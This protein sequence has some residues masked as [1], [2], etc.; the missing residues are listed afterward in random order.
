MDGS[1][2][3]S[4]PMNPNFTSLA[5]GPL[6]HLVNYRL[7]RDGIKSIPKVGNV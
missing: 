7:E 1:G 2:T 4:N 3:L 5:L 6:S